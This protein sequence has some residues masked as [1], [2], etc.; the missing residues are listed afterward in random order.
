MAAPP[1][2]EPARDPPGSPS[3]CNNEAYRAMVES[4]FECIEKQRGIL[5]QRYDGCAL[6]T[7]RE[8]A[9]WSRR[10]LAVGLGVMEMH[11]KYWE[12]E[13]YAVPE[14]RAKQIVVLFTA[15]KQTPP[16]WRFPED[17]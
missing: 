4:R 16:V 13:S 5:S 9:G 10:A 7:A 17:R 6:Q 2:S 1:E 15:Y 3:A 8:K 11:V 12:G 14:Y